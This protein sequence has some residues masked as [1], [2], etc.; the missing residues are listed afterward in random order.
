M[1][2]VRGRYT[3]STA[4]ALVWWA[5]SAAVVAL[6]RVEGFPGA[7]TVVE[8]VRPGYRPVVPVTTLFYHGDLNVN[9]QNDKS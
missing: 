1:V 9:S 8:V 7:W 3:T 6:S 2:V 4:D 5:V